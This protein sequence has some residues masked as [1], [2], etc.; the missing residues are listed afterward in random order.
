MPNASAFQGAA[1]AARIFADAAREVFTVKPVP[2]VAEWADE[3]YH[4]TSGEMQGLWNTA[5]APYAGGIFEALQDPL[6]SKVTLM[7]A[8]QLGGTAIIHAWLMWMIAND[9]ADTLL[10]MPSTEKVRDLKTQRLAPTIKACQ[11]VR[12]RLLRETEEI[13]GLTI[14]FARMNLQLLGSNSK[15]R[16]EGQP[17]RN[18]IVDEVDRCVPDILSTVGERVKTYSQS[19]IIALGTPGDADVGIDASYQGGTRERWQVPCPHCGG[20]HAR[21]W[22]NTRWQGG[23]D[24]TPEDVAHVA[25]FVCPHCRS[26]IEAHHNRWQQERGRWVPR[27]CGVTH[28]GDIVVPE[29]VRLLTSHRSF[30]LHGLDNALVANPYGKVAAPYLAERCQR[31]M[32]WTTDTLG[33]PWRPAAQKLEIQQL[34]DLCAKSTHQRGHV[35]ANVVALAAGCDVQ[36][37]RMYGLIVG[38]APGGETVYLINWA[39]LPLDHGAKDP[40]Q[41]LSAWID[42]RR[43]LKNESSL[44]VIAE[45]VDSGDS[46]DMVY[47]SCRMRGMV[48]TRSGMLL[49]RQPVKGATIAAPWKLTRLDD[50]SK[51]GGAGLDLLHVNST[52]WTD[53]VLSQLG[54]GGVGMEGEEEETEGAE[55]GHQTSD[56][57][58]Q[59]P[60]ASEPHVSQ[61]PVSRLSF[62]SDADE[63]LLNHFVHEQSVVVVRQG[64]RKRVYQL[65]SADAANHWCDALK[66]VWAGADARG[67]RNFKGTDRKAAEKPHT[68]QS[69]RNSQDATGGG[70]STVDKYARWLLKRN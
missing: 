9:P 63:E 6:V 38:F 31:T 21:N 12:E 50:S 23:K 68:Q 69:E 54:V 55:P 46:T 25:W 37:D 26:K 2:S 28:D 8:A 17:Y 43:W 48:R 62:P 44:P 7:K 42:G 57:R 70:V 10:V 39:E 13:E 4:L 61:S 15:S 27:G 51:A 32:V 45:F 14:R 33:E 64:V 66:Y 49:R 1:S 59:T 47:R 30:W 65:D 24:A 41:A 58:H 22:R 20:Y 52:F 34:K 53:A 29:S 56:M 36:T 3:H 60:D 18:V 16:I 35:P 67:I 5:N 40:M 19:K 11:P